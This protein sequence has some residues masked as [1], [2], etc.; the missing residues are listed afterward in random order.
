[1]RINDNRTVLPQGT[2]LHGTSCSYTII[3]M[4]GQGT[5]G[6]TY[7]ASISYGESVAVKEFFMREINGHNGSSVTSGNKK[8]MVDYYHKKFVRE[9]GNLSKLHHPN[10]ISVREAW[11]ENDTVYYS[12]EYLDGGSL[13]NLILSEGGLTEADTLR[14]TRE[15][16]KSVLVQLQT[17]A[18]RLQ[19]KKPMTRTIC[20]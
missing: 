11:A 14:Y 10:I 7:L 18:I 9:A 17:R 1:M 6:I 2:T 16:A 12:M 3:K 13:D 5:F 8:G 20:L 4:L 15:M 19:L